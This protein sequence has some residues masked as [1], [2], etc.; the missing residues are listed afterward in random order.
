MFR[1]VIFFL[2]RKNSILH[3]IRSTSIKMSIKSIHTAA[4][5]KAIILPL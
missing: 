4:A 2:F 1:K 3:D 5:S